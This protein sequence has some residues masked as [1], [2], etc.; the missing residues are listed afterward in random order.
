[1]ASSLAPEAHPRH[2]TTEIHRA[3]RVPTEGGGAGQK[4]VLLRRGGTCVLNGL[5]PGE[6]PASIFDLVLNR[7]TPE[8]ILASSGN[9][10][11]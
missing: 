7:Y 10:L 2:Q 8:F 3:S 9:V 6:F 11:L 4:Q 1:M 5:P